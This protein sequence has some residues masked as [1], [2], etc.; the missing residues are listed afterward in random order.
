[1]FL[2][3]YLVELIDQ[4]EQGLQMLHVAEVETSHRP[5]S[6]VTTRWFVVAD[7]SAILV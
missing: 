2:G 4:W 3:R 6:L 5:S 7:A 1:M